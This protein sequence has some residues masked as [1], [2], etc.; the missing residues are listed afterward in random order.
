MG[1]R[2][3]KPTPNVVR[4]VTG[5][6][7]KLPPPSTGPARRAGPLKPPAPLEGE[8]AELWAKFIRPAWWL[9]PAD[10]PLAWTWC[11][12]QAEAFADP[13]AFTAAR[14]AQLRQLAGD[15]GLTPVSRARLGAD[16]PPAEASELDEFFT[17]VS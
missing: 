13:K 6:R 3:Q 2:G 9:E 14:L 1:I 5:R 8:A 10:A 15:L 7:G 17:G 11:Q 16:A 4:L 12:V